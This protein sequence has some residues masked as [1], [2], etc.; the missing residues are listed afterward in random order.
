M[1]YLYILLMV[2]F[3]F[4]SP[5]LNIRAEDRTDPR[6][7]Q[8]QY[9]RFV[10]PNSIKVIL[11]SDPTV[12]HGAASL[13]VAVGSLNDP[14]EHP[15]MAHFLE[16]MLFL[17]TEKYPEVGD[18]Q[19]FLTSHDGFNNAF[20]ADETTNYYFQVAGDHMEE[21]LDRFAQFFIAP[22]FNPEFVTRELEVV[23]S[24]YTQKK[25]QR[26]LASFASRSFPVHSQPSCSKISHW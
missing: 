21:A 3:L 12:H 2:F 6:Y 14:D 1:R 22:L 19:K 8:R 15:G 20:T 17:G 5:Y 23:E 18:D 10:L 7:E 25:I 9:R 24:E 4:P 26:T 13:S 11:I 16:H